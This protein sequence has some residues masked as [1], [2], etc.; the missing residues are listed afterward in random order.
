MPRLV[1]QILL[2]MMMVVVAG[3]FYMTIYVT[4]DIYLPYGPF[5]RERHV[6]CFGL[7]GLG[8]WLVIILGW[9]LIWRDRLRTYPVGTAVRVGAVGGAFS[10]GVA[11]LVAL[12]LATGGRVTE[13]AVFLGS[14]SV[15]VTWLLLTITMWN[16]GPGQRHVEDSTVEDAVRCLKCGYSMRG[17]SEARCPECGTRYTLDELL[18]AQPG[19]EW[20]EA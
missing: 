19:R 16:N 7:S 12:D 15:P 2:T 14:V 13:L 1:R 5:W 18:A 10:A 17:L 11:V 4:L 3:M 8:A 9:Q 20:D 6:F